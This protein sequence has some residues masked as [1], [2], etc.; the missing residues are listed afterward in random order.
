M[1]RILIVSMMLMVSTLLGQADNVWQ[2]PYAGIWKISGGGYNGFS[3]KVVI[4]D[5]AYS[6]EVV[7]T[8]YCK[9]TGVIDNVSIPLPMQSWYRYYDASHPNE[10]YCATN[11]FVNEFLFAITNIPSANRHI[12]TYYSGTNI[13]FIQS[14]N[15]PL[16]VTCS[17]GEWYIYD[18]RYKT[19]FV[20]YGE[21]KKIKLD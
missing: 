5:V 17:S 14:A 2:A 7:T 12:L 1:N 6:R 15:E 20:R 19:Q 21:C 16:P 13:L 8:K 11:Y 10:I 9:V 18:D 3:A 4:T